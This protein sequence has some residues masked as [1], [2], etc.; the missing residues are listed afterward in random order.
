MTKPD[1]TALRRYYRSIASLLPCGGREKKTLLRTTRD[2]VASYLLDHPEADFARVQQ[3]FGTP[4]EIA[5]AFVG[6]MDMPRL[7]A[8]LRS[9]RRVFL[10][11]IAALVA[12]LLLWGG[13][14]ALTVAD[15]HNANPSYIVDG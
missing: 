12:A 7:L 13:G 8:A 4:E 10:A 14:V 1:E 2:S 15:Q 6:D 11:V 3:H 5:A 9:R